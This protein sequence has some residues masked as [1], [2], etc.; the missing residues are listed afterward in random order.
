MG[1]VSNWG[2][3]TVVSCIIRSGPD[4]TPKK[5]ITSTRSCVIGSGTSVSSDTTLR[6]STDQAPDRPTA[7]SYD[8]T[9][10]SRPISYLIPVGSSPPPKK[11]WREM[12]FD[13]RHKC[14]PF[15]RTCLLSSDASHGSWSR[16]RRYIS[17]GKSFTGNK[18]GVN[19]P[20]SKQTYPPHWLAPHDST[21]ETS[22]WISVLCFSLF[23]LP[24]VKKICEK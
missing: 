1:S 19:A 17:F 22:V 4:L 11:I 10:V 7:A 14:F 12:I 23:L 5:I 8:R 13:E 15:Q 18:S 6:R 9:H 16:E 21:W 24:S 20:L 2:H 3:S